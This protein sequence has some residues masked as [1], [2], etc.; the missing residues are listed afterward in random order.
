[1]DLAMVKVSDVLNSIK[2]SKISD[3]DIEAT[4][5]I[6]HATQ[7]LTETILTTDQDDTI[8]LCKN[9][10]GPIVKVEKQEIG[11]SLMVIG[12]LSYER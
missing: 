4:C 2:K 1:M 8:Y 11:Y 12:H 6:C 3:A 9:G 7:Q 5:K 10:C